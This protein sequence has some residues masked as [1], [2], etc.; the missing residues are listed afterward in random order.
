VDRRS[1]AN[2]IAMTVLNGSV[3]TR[4]GHGPIH[5]AA[6]VKPTVILDQIRREPTG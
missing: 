5:Y 6:D 1:L 3:N 2:E 4:N